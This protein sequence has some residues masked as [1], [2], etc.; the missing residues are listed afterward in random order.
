MQS[1]TVDTYYPSPN[2]DSLDSD[3]G[4]LGLSDALATDVYSVADLVVDAPAGLGGI[5]ADD[6]LDDM[7]DFDSR[8]D[9]IAKSITHPARSWVIGGTYES[10]E[11]ALSEDPPTLF[12]PTLSGSL[13]PDA[14]EPDWCSSLFPDLYPPDP[15]QIPVGRLSTW[16]AEAKSLSDSLLRTDQLA[17]LSEGLEITCESS[18]VDPR[19]GNVTSHRQVT[20]LFG[21]ADWLVRSSEDGYE[22]TVETCDRQRR[23][24]Y[25]AHSSWAAVVPRPR[26]N[27]VI[28]RSCWRVTC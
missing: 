4:Y 18:G 28:H 25:S 7:V 8:I 17:T 12:T 10:Y 5:G 2:S 22:T 27:C 14:A 21:P 9:L 26:K 19:W 24:I 16:P 6:A 23:E 20:V 11:D 13:G 1:L 3:D 15:V